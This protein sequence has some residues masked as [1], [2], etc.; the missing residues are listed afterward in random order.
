MKDLVV[1]AVVH[2]AD[3]FLVE[4][5]S[6]HGTF[7]HESARDDHPVGVPRSRVVREAAECANMARHEVG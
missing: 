7:Q 4:P 5:E 3:P 2:N 6:C 1:D